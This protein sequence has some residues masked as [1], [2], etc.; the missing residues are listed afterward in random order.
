MFGFNETIN[1]KE[2]ELQ[3]A[4]NKAE[5]YYQHKHFLEGEL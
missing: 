3:N 4:K 2:K 5:E 1:N